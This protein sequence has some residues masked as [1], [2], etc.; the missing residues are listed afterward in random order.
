M[1]IVKESEAR[2]RGIYRGGYRGRGRRGGRRGN[3]DWGEREGRKENEREGKGKKENEKEETIEIKLLNVQ[4][5]TEDKWI[6]ILEETGDDS[7][8]CL[9]ETKKKGR[10]HKNC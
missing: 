9:T 7:I 4:G 3:M 5:L 10:W 2:G 1:K 8:M 6:E